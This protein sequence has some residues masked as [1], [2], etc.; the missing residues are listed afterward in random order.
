MTETNSLI[1]H[2]PYLPTDIIK[3]YNRMK[4]PY[5]DPINISADS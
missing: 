2:L 4:L 3:K 1:Y 5:N